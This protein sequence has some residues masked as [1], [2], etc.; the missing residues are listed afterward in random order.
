[1]AESITVAVCFLQILKQKDGPIPSQVPRDNTTQVAGVQLLQV[2]YIVEEEE[3][4]KILFPFQA[5]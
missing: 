1:M 3:E 5:V 4:H 2:E